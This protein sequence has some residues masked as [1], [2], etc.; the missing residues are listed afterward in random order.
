MPVI[1]NDWL[2]IKAKLGDVTA[3]YAFTTAQ[4][5]LLLSIAEQLEWKKTYRAFGYDFSDWDLL[6]SEVAD[7]QR[8]LAMPV[9]VE[10]LINELTAIKDAVNALEIITSTE[11]PC[12]GSEDA[13]AGDLY[14]DLVIPGTGVIPENI[15]NA[16]FVVDEDDWDPG[17]VDYKCMIAYAL[18]LT[19]SERADNLKT[20]L[21]LGGVVVVGVGA[22]AGAIA[23]FFAGPS[24]L[25]VATIL[26]STGVA[27]VIW[28]EIFDTGE[29]VMSDISSLILA[30]LDD[31]ACAFISGD[32]AS[33]S[34]VALKSK[35]DELFTSSQSTIMKNLNIDATAKALYAGRYDQTNIAQL[36]ADAG[37]DPDDYDCTC[38][39]SYDFLAVWTNEFV[40]GDWFWHGRAQLNGDSFCPSNNNV[41]FNNCASEGAWI[42]MTVQTAAVQAGWAWPGPPRVAFC[43]QLEITYNVGSTFAS[44][45]KTLTL[46]ILYEDST[47]DS[48]ICDV[49][50]GIHTVQ[51]RGS[52]V[53]EVQAD[54]APNQ[55]VFQVIGNQ[56][57]ICN[58][59][60][61]QVC[62]TGAR[63]WGSVS[64]T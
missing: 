38:M 62:M 40:A 45:G 6:Q 19:L 23:L 61:A 57:G 56:S 37:M 31:L 5:S 35:M 58:D 41:K 17:Y 51:I 36:M 32:G 33:A 43:H 29:G 7:L 3:L 60:N 48:L 9:D 26:A 54:A 53:K 10:D 11:N 52:D 13:S 22:I 2:K 46:K 49:T 28:E 64:G 18:L 63:F 20:L 14:T 24:L 55:E 42:G 4:A 15:V 16:G 21:S 25:V 59:G 1:Q 50:P 30:N 44:S 47:F 39:F 27:A 8:G 12:C 34:S